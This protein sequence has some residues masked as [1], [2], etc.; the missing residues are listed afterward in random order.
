M[1]G[2]IAA[3]MTTALA[4]AA[5]AAAVDVASGQISVLPTDAPQLGRLSRNGVPQDFAGD[6]PYPGE[7]NPGT[8]YRYATLLVPFEPNRSQAVYYDITFDDVDT[9]LFASAYVG[10][11]DPIRKNVRWLGDAGTSGNYFGT[12]PL[13]FDVVVPAGKSLLLVFN[14]TSGIGPTSTANYFVQAFSDSEYDETFLPTTIPE[15]AAW[16]LMVAGFGLIG[17]AARHRRPAVA[18]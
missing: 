6:E 16:T 5:P 11:Y 3:M 7:I 8:S 9:D 1:R 15:P 17:V 4:G 18:A 14:S 2:I 12:D 10:R 13:F